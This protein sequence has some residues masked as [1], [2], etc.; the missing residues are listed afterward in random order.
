LKLKK[1]R[2]K[3]EKSIERQLKKAKV[4]FKYES[5][6]IPYV[7]SKHYVPDF[8]IKVPNG[9]IYVEVKGYLRP[10]DRSKMVAVK[11]QHPNKDFRIVFYGSNHK[12]IK[13]AVKHGFRY[14]I[15]KIPTEWLKGL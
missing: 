2:N 11:R 13:W 10:E 4:G 5:E 14:A 8:I 15:G 12:Y 9:L 6:K 1:T 7:L 3:F